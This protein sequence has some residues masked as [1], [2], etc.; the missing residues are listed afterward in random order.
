M[1]KYGASQLIMQW[2]A[3]GI[4]M[5]TIAMTPARP[6]SPEKSWLTAS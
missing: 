5:I 4:D 1:G 2:V 3:V 6:G